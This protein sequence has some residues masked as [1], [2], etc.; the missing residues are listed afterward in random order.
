MLGARASRLSTSTS[1]DPA[2]RSEQCRRGA[3]AAR[4]SATTLIARWKQIATKLMM[5]LRLFAVKKSA[6]AVLGRS[7]Y[8]RLMKDV[9]QHDD[10]SRSPEA[11]SVV[12]NGEVLGAPLAR[13][14]GVAKEHPTTCLHP[15][16]MIR[17][18]A[19]ARQRWFTCLQ[20]L[21]R[22][23]RKPLEYGGP[24]KETDYMRFGSHSD[25]TYAEVVQ[26]FPRYCHWVTQTREV[27]VDSCPMLKRF[28][29]WLTAVGATSHLPMEEDQEIFPD[30]IPICS[31]SET[32]SVSLNSEWA[33]AQ[34][35]E[36]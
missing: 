16:T 14:H 8:L 15:S 22:W 4:L 18:R 28:A 30:S 10:S 3:S 24:A 7:V 31:D 2:S 23:D 29:D 35:S 36:Q 12:I 32:G 33:Q 25:L 1:T 26:Q 17:P 6:Q 19:N 21:A 20:C 5:I 9:Q 34:G 11:P 13:G 27:E